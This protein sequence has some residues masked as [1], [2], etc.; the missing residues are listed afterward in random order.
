MPNCIIK[1]SRNEGYLHSLKYCN[2]LLF[3]QIINYSCK[4]FPPEDKLAV[5][6]KFMKVIMK[7][8]AH[9]SFKSLA[10]LCSVLKMS[11]LHCNYAI[12]FASGPGW[13]SAIKDS[14]W[15]PHN[16]ETAY[17]YLEHSFFTMTPQSYDWHTVSKITHDYVRYTV[18]WNI[19]SYLT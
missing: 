4:N 9:W 17:Y 19:S 8:Y 18:I 11:C 14:F 10:K 13:M 5:V 6:G 12:N 7:H 2:K 1:L 15:K 3:Q 16:S